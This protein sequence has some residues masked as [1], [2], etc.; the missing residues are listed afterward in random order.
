MNNESTTELSPELKATIF[1]A[2]VCL[3]QLL[4][5]LI[6][7]VVHKLLY[8]T[9]TLHQDNI[10]IG[11]NSFEVIKHKPTRSN[12]FEDISTEDDQTVSTNHRVSAKDIILSSQFGES[13]ISSQMPTL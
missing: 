3:L 1:G 8:P 6:M 12:R 11:M 5:A 9:S 2:S 13:V 10:S 4:V 7:Y